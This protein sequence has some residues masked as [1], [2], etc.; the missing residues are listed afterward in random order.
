MMNTYSRRAE[1]WKLNLKMFLAA[2][3][4]T[5]HFTAQSL[6]MGSWRAKK[7]YKYFSNKIMT[8]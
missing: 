8:G 6:L 3:I 5:A 4:E 1:L 7:V 2:D